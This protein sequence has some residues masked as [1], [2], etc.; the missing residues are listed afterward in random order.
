MAVLSVMGCE[1]VATTTT[2][3]TVAVSAETT[4]TAGAETTTTAAPTTTTT[5]A[6]TTTKAPPKATTTTPPTK[7][8][9]APTEH[10]L[11][12][13]WEWDVD[14]DG[15]PDVWYQIVDELVHYLV[16]E[17]GAGFALITS[18]TFAA[19]GLGDLQSASYSTDR[20]ATEGVDDPN[21]LM[22]GDVL[23]LRTSSGRYAK[24]EVVEVTSETIDG[25]MVISRYNVR[26]RYVLY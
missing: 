3:T 20:L 11:K 16:P 21:V 13:T 25:G 9:P 23:G 22:P 14:A 2:T 4:T 24:I 1:D 17:N 18:K 26:L 10:F 8:G 5:A 19:L 6:P 15:A 7:A 12:G